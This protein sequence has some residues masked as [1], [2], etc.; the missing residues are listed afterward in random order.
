M[1]RSF[2]DML[3]NLVHS[4]FLD[5]NEEERGSDW[6]TRTRTRRV[7]PPK[8]VD[9]SGFTDNRVSTR[10]WA[11]VTIAESILWGSASEIHL[12]SKVGFVEL[13]ANGSKALNRSKCVMSK[14]LEFP[15]GEATFPLRG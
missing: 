11:K 8:F 13:N 6:D 12:T 10:Y 4:G 5:T 15:E 3:I 2:F 1:H 14:T 7:K 9:K